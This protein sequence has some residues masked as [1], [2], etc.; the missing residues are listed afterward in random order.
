M[1]WKIRMPYIS[2]EDTLFLHVGSR[3]SNHRHPQSRCHRMCRLSVLSL[4]GQCCV[5]SDLEL[6]ARELYKLQIRIPCL[7]Q[8]LDLDVIP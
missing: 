3:H 5:I 8:T 2:K 4:Y 6:S 1:L 7:I